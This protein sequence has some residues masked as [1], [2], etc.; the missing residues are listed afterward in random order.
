MIHDRQSHAIPLISRPVSHVSRD[1][2]KPSRSLLR[3]AVS[4]DWN[5]RSEGISASCE[6]VAEWNLPKN[7][8]TVQ[9]DVLYSDYTYKTK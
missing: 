8:D 5:V 7:S 3:L 1:E 9:V 2:S 4:S 6:Q